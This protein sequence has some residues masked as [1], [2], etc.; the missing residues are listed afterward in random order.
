MG[1]E[2]PSEAWG[3]E[4]LLITAIVRRPLVFLI[5]P[6]IVGGS[7]FFRM[8]LPGIHNGGGKAYRHYGPKRAQVQL[9]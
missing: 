5:V 6:R 4:T 1:I 3:K 9:D 7:R 2:P 8:D